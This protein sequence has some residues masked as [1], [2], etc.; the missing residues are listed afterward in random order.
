MGVSTGLD[1]DMMALEKAVEDF[2]RRGGNVSG[3]LPAAANILVE[4]VDYMFD[5]EG[6]AG[7]SGTWEP[8]ARAE[9]QSGQTL[10]DTGNLAGSIT[11]DYGGSGLASTAWFEA[12][13][14]VPYAVFHLPPD[15]SGHPSKGIMPVRDFF[16]VKMDD[17]LDEVGDLF[18]A[19]VTGG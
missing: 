11:G 6:G 15:R 7:N 17:I 9:E 12:G 4:A 3:I 14:N 10:Q 18:L 13:T 8:S 16:D 19:E 5:T 1:F 2:D